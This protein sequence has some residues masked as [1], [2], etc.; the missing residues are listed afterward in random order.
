MHG[1]VTGMILSGD[2][3][4]SGREGESVGQFG[5]AVLEGFDIHPV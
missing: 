1:R 4:V 2:W 3:K 5:E